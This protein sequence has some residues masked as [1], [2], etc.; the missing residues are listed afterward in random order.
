MLQAIDPL[1]DPRIA[2]I[3]IECLQERFPVEQAPKSSQI[4]RLTS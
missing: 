3:R 1:A 2:P 4:H